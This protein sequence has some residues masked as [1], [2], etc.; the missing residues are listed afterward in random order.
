[1]SPRGLDDDSI[2]V[3]EF[4]ETELYYEVAQH[5]G[6]RVRQ[7]KYFKL[8]YPEAFREAV[9][10]VLKHVVTQQCRTHILDRIEIAAAGR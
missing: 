5:V 8:W 9:C 4:L 6:V 10:Y 2:S 7:L 3:A 1:M